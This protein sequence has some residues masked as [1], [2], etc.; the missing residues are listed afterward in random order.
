ME[1]PCDEE[2][3][4]KEIRNIQNVIQ[5]TKEQLEALNAEFGNRKHPPSMYLKE[6]E[7]LTNKI[8]ELQL[9]QQELQESLVDDDDLIVSQNYE[10]DD[11]STIS[12]PSVPNSSLNSKSP[13]RNTVKCYLPNK[14]ISSIQVRPGV[15][16]KDALAK[17]MRLRELSADKCIVYRQPS[18]TMVTWDTDIALLAGQEL[19]IEQKES[20]AFPPTTSIQHN[21]IRKTFFT[22]AFC[23][24]CRKLVFQG[25]KCQTCTARYHPRCAERADPRCPQQDDGILCGSVDDDQLQKR[26]HTKHLLSRGFDYA[27][28]PALPSSATQMPNRRAY[29]EQRSTSVP[30]V[31]RLAN[32]DGTLLQELCRE[33]RHL[34]PVPGIPMV[35]DGAITFAGTSKTDG[36]SSDTSPT[37]QVKMRHSRVRRSRRD[38]NEE[39]EIPLE[40][41]YVGPRIG[42]GSFG[43]VYRGQW[44]GPVAIKRLNVKEPTPAQL[45][46]FKNEVAVLKRTRHANVLLFMGCTSAPYLAIITQWCEGS[47]LYKHLHV[48]EAKFEMSQII[49]IARQTAQGIDYL[50]AK[51]IIHR[52]LKSN[53]I[54]LADNYCIKIGDF[55][56]ATVKTRWSGSDQF[57]QP[58]GSILWMSPEIIRMKDENPYSFK[59]DVYAF[60]VVLFELMTG[61][62]PYSNINN[63]DQILFMVGKGYLKPDISLARSDTPRA[64]KRLMQDCIKFDASER[65]LFPQIL[66]S[67]ENLVRS[68]PKVHRSVSEP[69]LNRTFLS[70]DESDYLTSPRTPMNTQL[71]AFNFLSVAVK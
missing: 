55:G 36:Q 1:D 43:T 30:N 57:Q 65:P 21:F 27:T 51:N 66:A 69:T 41:I 61:Q 52:D 42:S 59:S 45:E 58:T 44:H 15:T 13:L 47:S 18:N 29:A 46:A 60:G 26:E 16:L 70:N 39:W 8:H 35:E 4:Q 68:L 12:L 38:S 24:V 67:L 20:I 3:I 31:N 14:Q 5:L 10:P 9:K 49:D 48:G 34:A 6:Y 23:D 7:G 56:L 50:H 37:N 22:L 63:K 71:W 32:L 33:D 64:F 2:Q 28:Q 54:F 62:L 53:N 11:V 19:V 25:L 40:E 17:G